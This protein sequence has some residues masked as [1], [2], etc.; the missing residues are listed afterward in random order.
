MKRLFANCYSTLAVGSWV[1]FTSLLYCSVFAAE[2]YHFREVPRAEHYSTLGAT[3]RLPVLVGSDRPSILSAR[4]QFLCIYWAHE[5]C[6]A[7]CVAEAAYSMYSHGVAASW[8]KAAY[9]CSTVRC[10]IR[11]PFANVPVPTWTVNAC[12]S[13]PVS[14]RRHFTLSGRINLN[15]DHL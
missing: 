15:T 5:A 6:R 3:R 12:H 4:T 11:F 14:R 8:W 2:R 10:A 13:F 9:S 1:R 7:D